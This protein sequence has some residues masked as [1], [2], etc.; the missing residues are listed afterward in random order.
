[1]RQETVVL[2]GKASLTLSPRIRSRLLF[3]LR[4][5]AVNLRG[6]VHV[7]RASGVPA[8]EWTLPKGAYFLR[9]HG[10]INL[11]GLDWWCQAASFVDVDVC[12]V[13]VNRLGIILLVSIYR[14]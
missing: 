11:R 7:F 5:V 6:V 10:S 8:L 12:H 14:A 1:M 13:L 3:G 9:F 2:K 4:R